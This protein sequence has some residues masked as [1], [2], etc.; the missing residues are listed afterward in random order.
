M[1]EPPPVTTAMCLSSNPV[2]WSSLCRVVERAMH[3]GHT[4]G[5]KCAFPDRREK[6]SVRCG[7]G[8]YE[9]AWRTV[10]HRKVIG[11]RRICVVRVSDGEALY[12]G[13]THHQRHHCE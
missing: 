2:I 4:D 1:P 11:C 13:R 9:R 10:T 5:V 6:A 12:A 8:I 7:G 3:S